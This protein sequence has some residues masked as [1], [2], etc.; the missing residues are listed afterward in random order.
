MKDRFDCSKCPGYCC[1]HPRIEVTENDIKRLA[2][3]FGLSAAA[4]KKKFTYHFKTKDADEQILRHHKDHVYATICRFF[5]RD[6]RRCTV[7]E[8]RPAVC[9]KYPY[10]NKCGYYDF[11]KFEREHQ[12]DPEFIPSA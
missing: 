8:A 3:H 10:G 6:E 1:S 12:D 11:L 7:Y 5:D 2:K 9:R 4:A